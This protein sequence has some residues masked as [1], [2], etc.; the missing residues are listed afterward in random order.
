[1]STAARFVLL[2]A[3]GLWIGTV[4]CFS[5][6]VAPVVFTV[7]G[8]AQAGDVV[9]AIFPAYYRV[10]A[11]AGALSVTGGLMLRRHASAPRAW[12]WVVAIAAVGLAATLWAGV[13]VHPAARARRASLAQAGTPPALDP[14]FER[15][16][17]RAV[18]LNGTALLTAVGALG[19]TARALRT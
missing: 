7:L 16:H 18:V 13:V 15:L 1:V 19:A 17:R 14:E 3:L 11:V 9:G 12:S 10:G 2:L 8:P 5:F 6:L 4:A